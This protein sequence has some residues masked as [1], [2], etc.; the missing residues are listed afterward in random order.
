MGIK[1]NRLY[2]NFIESFPIVFLFFLVFT[3]FDLSIDY[4]LN[5]SFNL[6]YILIFFWILKKPETLGVGLIFL[7]GIINDVLLNLPIG[8]SSIN[9]LILSG[10][11]SFIRSRTLK[12]NLLYD[13]FFFL[14]SILIVNSI[15]FIVLTLIFSLSINYQLLLTNSFFTF[16]IY[17]LFSKIFNKIYLLNINKQND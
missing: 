4:I 14:L 11:A 8:I 12:P 6:V 9:Y 16:L 3:S 17:P 15:Y 13:W 2:K 7:A 5:I 1:S 10:I